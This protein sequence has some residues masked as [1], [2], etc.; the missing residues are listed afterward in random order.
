MTDRKV[1]QLRTGLVLAIAALIAVIALA[2]FELRPRIQKLSKEREAFRI[3]YE[4]NRGRAMKAETYARGL[5]QRLADAEAQTEISLQETK[6]KA[7]QNARL[8]MD[9]EEARAKLHTTKQEL[10]RWNATGATPEQVASLA[11][12]NKALAAKL[13]QVQTNYDRASR[14]VARIKRTQDPTFDD[15]DVI[16]ELPPM[17]GSV[18]VV[19]PKWGFVVLNLGEN[20][21][22]LKNGVL[23]ISRDGKLVS[24]VQV[25]HVGP[26]RSI[27]DIL[28]GWRVAE[29]REGDQAMN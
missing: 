29:I 17:L 4:Q 9:L 3:S 25:R 20:N 27:A 7:D 1:L 15:S 13:S 14:E 21:G 6:Q 8:L 23:M 11:R 16:P 18:L 19:D 10:A 5:T 12:D 28:P 24:K 2:F 26:E 22:L